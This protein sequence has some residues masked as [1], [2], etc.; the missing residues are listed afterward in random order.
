[1]NFL[2]SLFGAGQLGVIFNAWMVGL[3]CAQGYSYYLNFPRDSMVLKILVAWVLVLQIFNL[4]VQATTMY[5]Y[6]IVSFGDYNKILEV[7]WEWSL[8]L[9]LIALAA[10]SVQLF[11]AYRIFRLSEKQNYLSFGIIVI[12]ALAALG[13]CSAI[14]ILGLTADTN[15]AKLGSATWLVKAWLCVDGT[16]DLLI[17]V[18]QV[19][20]LYCQ[21]SG[22]P[23]TTR[24]VNTL[25]LYIISTGLLTSILV[26]FELIS[27]VVLGFNFAHVFLSYQMGAI[28]TM[29][30]L[31]NLDARRHMRLRGS[32]VIMV[33]SSGRSAANG[34]H[35][36]NPGSTGELQFKMNN[37]YSKMT[38]SQF[39]TSILNSEP[40]VIGTVILIQQ[41]NSSTSGLD[42]EAGD[43]RLSGKEDK[44]AE[45]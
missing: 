10:C 34:P 1:M 42:K 9:G 33:D 12:L 24:F 21:R 23:R 20:Y 18:F 25:I 43:S 45:I 2:A 35:T 37:D 38:S 17:A 16:C 27:F 13:L 29:S 14:T 7:T 31:A 44:V 4:F 15:F 6:L 39:N 40:D 26:L 30:F 28:H 36:R 8:Y 5:H 32:E 19:Y 3:V 22:L 11:Y 41:E